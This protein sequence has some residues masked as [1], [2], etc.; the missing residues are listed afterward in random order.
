MVNQILQEEVRILAFVVDVQRV[1][2]E[3]HTLVLMLS[4][5]GLEARAASMTMVVDLVDFDKLTCVVCVFF[6]HYS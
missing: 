5:G 4:T 2:V 1:I 6:A 3:E